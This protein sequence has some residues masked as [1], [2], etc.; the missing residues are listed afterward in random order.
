MKQLEDSGILKRVDELF[1]SSQTTKQDSS[2]SLDPMSQMK[3]CIRASEKISG[4]IDRLQ[5]F[6]A[7]TVYPLFPEL[8]RLVYSK[9][10]FIKC[11][12]RMVHCVNPEN[13]NL[14]ECTMQLILR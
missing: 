11:L 4:V 8:E 5:R 10:Q 12:D 14:G 9:E 2:D 13:I 6:V 1:S 3:V 7:G